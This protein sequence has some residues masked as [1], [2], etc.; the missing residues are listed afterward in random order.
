MVK[1]LHFVLCIL[2]AGLNDLSHSTQVCGFSPVWVIRW[3]VRL[4]AWINDF[5]HLVHLCGFSPV[6]VRKWVV[7]VLITFLARKVINT[8]TTHF[9]TH[10]GEKPHKCTR[11]PKSFIQAGNLTDHL[12]THTGEKPHTCVE[13][14]KSFSP[15]DK[16]HRTKCKY[17][18]TPTQEL[19]RGLHYCFDYAI[20]AILFD[21]KN[22]G[23]CL[24]FKSWVGQAY[25]KRLN[26]KDKEGFQHRRC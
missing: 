23:W 26:Y 22:K 25:Y 1:Y 13:C 10:T 16:M 9:L 14:D 17:L 12:M 20:I 11:C 15:A 21:R 2:S 7:T 24:L 5:G 19:E 6:W 8:V 4:P 18:T 3:S